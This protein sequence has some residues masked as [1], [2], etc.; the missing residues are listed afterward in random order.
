[1]LFLLPLEAHSQYSID[2]INMCLMPITMDRHEAMRYTCAY[3]KPNN[4]DHQTLTFKPLVHW[5]PYYL[6][7]STGLLFIKVAP[8]C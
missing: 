3:A 4:G 8:S 5:H 2:I 1:M 6:P 7:C